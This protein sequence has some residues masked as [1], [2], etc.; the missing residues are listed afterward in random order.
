LPETEVGK[1]QF[2]VA[3]IEKEFK[4]F[5]TKD[6]PELENNQETEFKVACG[7]A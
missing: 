5:E 2:K 1:N 6:E 7:R 4:T 3:E